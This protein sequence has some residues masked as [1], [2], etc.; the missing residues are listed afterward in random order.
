MLP[1]F[2]VRQ[3]DYLLEIARLLT[4]ELDLE[5]LLERILRVSVEMLAGQAGLIALKEPE[6]WR[7]AAAHNIQPAFLNYLIPLLGEENVR[8]LDVIELNRM[9]KELTYTAS[10]G[11]LNGTGLPLAAHGQVIG[12]IFIFRNY[13][14]LFTPNDRTL[15]QSFA[16]QAA[17]AVF[18]AQLYGQVNYEKQRVEAL[19]DSAADGML[20]LDGELAVERCNTAFERLFGGTREQIVGR[21][22]DQVIQWA[23]EPQGTT[24]EEARQAGWPPAANA[25]LYVEGDLRRPLPPAVPVGI[26]YAPL[27]S[28]DGRLRNIIV[29]VRDITHFRT[30]EEIKSTF[31][32]IVS[33]ELRTPVALIKGYASTLRRDDARWDRTVVRDSLTVIEEEADRLSKMIDDLLDASRLQAGGLSLNRADVSL[34]VVAERVAQLF[35]GQSNKHTLHTEFPAGFPIIVA[36]ETRLEQV[37]SNLV[38]NSLKYAPQGAITIEGSERPGQIVVCVTDEGPGIDPND[39]PHIF[40]RFYRSEAAVKHTKGAGLGLYLARAI[41]EAHGGRIWAEAPGAPARRDGS[42]PGARICFSLPR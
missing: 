18:N 14:D 3:R 41:V 17:V 7:V 21:G 27:L 30:A 40:D 26:T 32:S 6:G 39:L 4:E 12:V 42:G 29:S 33:H 11:L 36:D 34:K 8:E 24:L 38:S 37:L 5:K 31:I 13:A 2:R 25:T 28:P 35:K 15:L 22:H 10:L 9:L 16:D 20:I 23:G 1:D 19:L